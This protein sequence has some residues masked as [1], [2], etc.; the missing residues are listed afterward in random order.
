MLLSTFKQLCNTPYLDFAKAYD[1]LD[2]AKIVEIATQQRKVYEQDG[3]LGLVIRCINMIPARK[4]IKLSKVYKTVELQDVI[5][6]LKLVKVEADTTGEAV[7]R[8]L[9]NDIEQAKAYVRQVVQALV[10]IVTIY[11][12]EVRLLLILYAGGGEE[13]RRGA[14]ACTRGRRS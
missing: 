5:R 3:T 2:T 4:I 13:T 7:G 11:R 10:G 8:V 14:K 6:S 1:T 12:H 9:F